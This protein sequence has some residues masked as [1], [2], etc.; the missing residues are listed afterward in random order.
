M[1]TEL[2]RD[3]EEV[4]EFADL[5]EIG[6]LSFW[7]ANR[8][9][10][11]PGGKVPYV[12]PN[13]SSI[14]QELFEFTHIFLPFTDQSLYGGP[15]AL[16]ADT[17]GTV[18]FYLMAGEG[19][20]HRSYLLLGGVTGTAPGIPLPGGQAVLPV[21]WDPFTNMVLSMLN[22]P[23]FVDFMGALDGSGNGT[24]LLNLPALGTGYAGLKMYYA[25][26]LSGPFDF[27]SNP[28][29]IELVP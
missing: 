13:C 20:A 10:Q 27:A 18:H 5:T 22:G 9:N 8:D 29:E 1:A 4:L 25:Y 26:C 17:G 14:L 11:C 23:V 19:N 16:P 28:V 15:C 12:S 2:E 7:S 6:M 24:A 21:N 3:A